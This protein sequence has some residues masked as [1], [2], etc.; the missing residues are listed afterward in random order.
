M[1][2]KSCTAGKTSS[3]RNQSLV[4]E[5]AEYPPEV[6]GL[7]IYTYV[8]VQAA[9]HLHTIPIY[10]RLIAGPF[11]TAAELVSMDDKHVGEWLSQIPPYYMAF[12]PNGSKHALGAGITQ[13]RYRNLRVVM[14]RP[15]LVRWASTSSAQ[16]QLD[17]SSSENVAVYRCLAAAKESIEN[18]QEYWTYRD[19][20][21]L[22]AWYVL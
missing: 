14:Y 7:T 15:F 21:R 13:W 20:S 18:M 5:A 9:Y 3:L 6:D 8:R 19:Q 12:L 4:S 11:P 22:G 16:S 1:V 10:N 2:S 17:S